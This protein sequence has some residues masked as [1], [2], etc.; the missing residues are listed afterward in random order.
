MSCCDVPVQIAD[1]GLDATA[2][3]LGDSSSHVDG[4]DDVQ[5][6][7]FIRTEID[8]DLSLIHISPNAGGTKRPTKLK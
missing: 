5:P 7:F 2:F 6:L 3:H 4:G 1:I 8:T